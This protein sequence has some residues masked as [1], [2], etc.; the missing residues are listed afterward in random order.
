MLAVK[1]QYPITDGSR[2]IE[3]LRTKVIALSAP[4]TR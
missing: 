2:G 4:K 1:H 3:P